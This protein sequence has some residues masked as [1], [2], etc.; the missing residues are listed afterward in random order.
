VTL[1]ADLSGFTGLSERL[2]RHGTA[3]TEQLGALIRQTIGGAL[4]AVSARGGDAI[5]FGGDAI[6]A[7]FE[8]G[9]AWADAQDAAQDI[10]EL[11]A[12][13]RGTPTLAGPLELA[14][15]IGIGGG[16]VTSD[17]YT[18]RARHV[19]AHIGPG[20]DAAE[21]AQQ[22]APANGSAVEDARLELTPPA[23]GEQE[24]AWA[25]RTLHPVTAQRVAA[26]GEPPDEHRHVTSFFVSVPPDV[27]ALGGFVTTAADIVDELGGDVLQ[28]SGGDKGVV[29]FG[30]FGTP[31][32]H[33]DDAARAVH[34]V[35]RLRALTS[36]DFAAG[37][38]SGLAFAATF[39]GR[40]RTF[41][42]ALGRT[43]NLA[44]RLMSAAGQGATLVDER[45]AEAL[46]GRATLGSV[47]SESLK[48][49][50]APVAVAEVRSLDAV[51]PQFDSAG[52]TPLVGRTAELAAA[53]RLLDDLGGV[54]RIVGDPGSGKS[55][56]AGEIA[57]RA[58]IRGLRVH[59]GAFDAFGL[60][61][62]LAPFGDL[63]RLVLGPGEPSAAIEQLLPGEE[64]LAPLLGPVL[65]VPLDET[66]L[67]AGL[68]DDAR[69]ELR[70]RLVVDLLCA[71]EK[72]TLAV[73]EDLH[74]A[75]ELSLRALEALEA[76][77]QGSRFALVVTSRPG[78]IETGSTLPE[79]RDDDIAAIV[80]DT[81]S[82]LGGGQLPEEYVA[83]LADRAAGSPLF[84]ETVTELARHGARP[85]EPLP[86]V[87]VPDQLLPFLTVQL[88]G[89]GDP[90]QETALRAAVLGRPATGSELAEVFGGEQHTIDGHLALLVEAAIARRTGA[91]TWL[92]HATVAEALLARAAHGT[93]APLHERVCR[94]LIEHDAPARE[95]AR[96]LEHCRMP[97][98]EV[99]YLRQARGE[100]WAAWALVEARHWAELTIARDGAG[101]AADQLVLAELEQ[102]LG[103]PRDALARLARLPASTEVAGAV[104]RLRGRIAFENGRPQEAVDELTRAEAAGAVDAS[105]S[106]PLTLAL[107]E[108]GRFEEARERASRQLAAAGPDEPRL[109]LDALANLGSVVLHQG[110]LETAADVL[111]QARRLAEDLGDVMRLAHV[112]GDLAGA[113]FRAGRLSEAARLL[114]EATGLAHRLGARR[115]VAMTLGNLSEIRL[116][117]GDRNGAG[118]AALAGA[119]S[120]LAIGDVAMAL[121]CAQ[122]PA[123]IAELDGETGRAAQWWRRLAGLEQR[124]GRPVDAATCWLRQ[125]A[126][127]AAADDV[128]AARRGIEMATLAADGATTTDLELLRQRALDACAGNY[129][130]PPEA[131]TTPIDLPPLDTA[132]PTVTPDAVDDLYDRIEQ[133]A[134]FDHR[135]SVA[136]ARSAESS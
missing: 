25:E 6:T 97:D 104:A 48:G 9:G 27:D 55:R 132:L 26:G 13:A 14:V 80:R 50:A 117:A 76:Q 136:E 126:L 135:A 24:P 133:T 18:A 89:L 16:S 65:E 83:T 32:A 96:H 84:A 7:T 129:R 124:L 128:P 53:E 43:T 28:C 63:L 95:I 10:V 73:L 74:W 110:D 68:E 86:S 31:V 59:E 123:V 120:A 70:E 38:A 94:H 105:V 115:T 121:D 91:R 30:V 100:A 122:V 23:P 134:A 81:W 21:R 34:A 98:L 108:L 54:L 112:T 1:F 102:Q 29:L 72:P 106:W 47:R 4:D 130:P 39:G 61:R 19:L 60:G 118:R 56:L 103:H 41:V 85:G 58:R 79:L 5:A 69:A 111:E 52:T 125:A 78:A 127:L 113:R 11:V 67:T 109:R 87:P 101:D 17:V 15:R 2:A 99:G 8:S 93:R 12:A 46:R 37:I 90:A 107:S 88:D 3:G 20:L 66:A 22:R 131:D 51:E 119:E 36:L 45:T 114:D 82:R 75:D 64:L 40:S 33:P 92:R 49:V 71:V 77:L 116:A 35:E 57:R 62:P 42:S 44:A